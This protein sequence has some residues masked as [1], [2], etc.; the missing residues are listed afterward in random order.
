M[1]KRALGIVLA[2]AIAAFAAPSN[3]TAATPPS[4]TLGSY[5]TASNTFAAA[6]VTGD[7]KTLTVS[8][9]GA[10][11]IADTT[12]AS[13]TDLNGTS[14]TY[15]VASAAAAQEKLRS[16][17]FSGTSNATEIEVTADGNETSKLPEG[18]KLTQVGDHYY[19]WV[20]EVLSWSAAYNK[21]KTFKYNGMQ[22][23]LA[24]ITSDSEYAALQAISKQGSWVGGTIMVY[25]SGAKINDESELPQKE[26]AFKF[27]REYGAE[28]V[29]QRD[30]AYNDY[31]WACG[32][33]AGKSLS[34][35]STHSDGEPNAFRHTRTVDEIKPA[36]VTDVLKMTKWESCLVAN[37]SGTDVIN[38]LI[39]PGQDGIYTGYFVE[40]GG[41]AEGKDPGKG[42]P[43]LTT[44]VSYSF[45]HQHGSWSYSADGATLTATCGASEGAC[46]LTDR[47]VA[48]TI[49]AEGKTY[50]G[51]AASVTVGTLAEQKAWKATDLSI[52]SV[53]YKYR[54]TPDDEWADATEAVRAGYYKACISG[55]SASA[56]VEFAI[57]KRAVTVSGLTAKVKTYDG[58][59][60]AEL[61]T[62]GAVFDSKV[63]GDSLSVTGTAVFESPSAGDGKRVVISDLALTGDSAANYELA[64][65]GNQT[66][67]GS[68]INK[69]VVELTWGNAE[70]E[71]DGESHAPTCTLGNTVA[72]DDVSATVSG[73]ETNAGND[74]EAVVSL[75]GNEASN[76]ALPESATKKFSIAKAGI[77]PSVSLDGWTYGDEAKSPSV[78]GNT[79]GG[80]VTYTYYDAEG[81]ALSGQPTDA[82]TYS[83]K[84][85]VAETANYKEATTKPC[86]FTIARKDISN[87][88]IELGD[89][90][91]CND[92]EQEQTVKS[93]TVDGLA[94]TYTVSDNKATKAGEYTLTVTGTGNF[95][96]T[97]TKK[98]TVAP[99]P[100]QVAADEVAELIEK[101]GDVKYNDDSKEAIEAAK[102]AYDSLTDEQKAR[103]DSKIVEK[104]KQADDEYKKLD[105]EVKAA[106]DAVSKIGDVKYDGASKEAIEAAKKAYD[107]LDDEQKK[108]IDPK[109]VELLKKS[110]DEYKKL[111]DE[112]KAAE[113]AVS[114]IG[115]VKYDGASKEAIEAAKKAYDALDDEQKKAIDPKIVELLKKSEDEYEKLD[116]EVKAAEEAISKILDVDAT[117]ASK[118]AIEAAKK[119]YD[120][121]T[122][123]QKKAIDAKF[124]KAV[125]KAEETYTEKVAEQKAA[126][127]K[128]A[129]EKAAADAKAAATKKTVTTKT[130][131]IPATGDVLDIAVVAVAIMGIAA[132]A[133]GAATRR[134]S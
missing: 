77:A 130:T 88:T 82:G 111:D 46:G 43:T 6:E 112:V 109:I 110:E 48:L 18:A 69:R 21:A 49:S 100:D 16:L 132:I 134:R 119:A 118:E 8:V 79:S 20:G 34:P 129:A 83:V 50:D 2:A 124:P 127:E 13:T 104:L 103:V 44:A 133:L 53:T 26:G 85:T 39:E 97:A 65:E 106:E 59:T 51:Q 71:Y 37:N 31:Y 32:P 81:N 60:D 27:M 78:S 57:N 113:D 123:E 56:E 107:A 87:A 61:V 64:A 75:G 4:V 33:D 28:G 10:G 91:I 63:T 76:Y 15:A 36:S 80:A 41:Y 74:Y 73:A 11:K 45:A 115:D 24:T 89:S 1:K 114:K 86:E 3:A 55:G 29:G 30:I 93:V 96:G 131:V 121:L 62:S 25:S 70:F 122:D 17:T 54:A 98:F 125:A 66:T 116:D 7:V 67:A 58:T 38:D 105:G 19:M 52:P 120:S 126:A 99:N 101:I 68:N 5:S 42:D 95:T 12:G 92:A 22:G 72:G 108:A 9:S 102:K 84:A 94:V 47:K 35:L 14:A 90:L 128:A 40:F 23:Y 117:D